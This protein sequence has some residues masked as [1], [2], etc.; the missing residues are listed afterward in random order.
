TKIRHEAGSS[1][2]ESFSESEV[3]KRR[4]V[5]I[6]VLIVVLTLLLVGSGVGQGGLTEAPA[7]FDAQ[8][9]GFISQAQYDL[10]KQ[11][12]IEQDGLDEGLG[13]VYNAQSCGECHQNPV[14]GGISQVTELRAGF[15]DGRV[16]IDEPGGS[17]INDR[18]ID[19]SIQE[20]VLE[21]SNVATLRTSLNTLGDGFVE[22]K[23][24]NQF[25][26]IADNTYWQAFVRLFVRWI[27]VEWT[28][29]CGR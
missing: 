13:P 24:D 27:N 12:F 18:A 29:S 5:S 11:V 17:L 6:G 1:R 16:F 23:A 26:V 4:S 9:N 7:G 25:R 15:F 21:G 14:T 28:V 22:A 19:P 8:T 3:M 20:R 2:Q 10:D